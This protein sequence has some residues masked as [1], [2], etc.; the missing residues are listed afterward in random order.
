MGVLVWLG[1]LLRDSR[2]RAL[3]PLRKLS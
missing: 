3:I 2:I 1:V